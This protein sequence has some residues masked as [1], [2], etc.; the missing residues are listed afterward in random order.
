MNNQEKF[1]DLS[2]EYRNI[3]LD[4]TIHLL[5][6]LTTSHAIVEIILS[7]RRSV[8]VESRYHPIRHGK[9]CGS[10]IHFGCADGEVDYNPK[11]IW[12]GSEWLVQTFGTFYFMEIERNYNGVK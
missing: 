2:S 8:V 12:N 3:I 11:L 4:S 1:T 6:S 9:F 5:P 10:K 7:N